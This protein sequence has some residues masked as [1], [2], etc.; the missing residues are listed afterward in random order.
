MTQTNVVAMDDVWGGMGLTDE[1]TQD[2]QRTNT[3]FNASDYTQ[4]S[5]SA[6]AGVQNANSENPIDK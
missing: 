4:S 2:V 1:A 5:E 6:S 3:M